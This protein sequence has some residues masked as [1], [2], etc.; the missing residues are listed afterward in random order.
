MAAAPRHD[1]NSAPESFSLETWLNPASFT[2]QSPSQQLCACKPPPALLAPQPPSVGSAGGIPTGKSGKQ[3]LGL[4][5]AW[6]AGSCR[7]LTRVPQC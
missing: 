2:Q 5:P 4:A 1:T 7:L 3:T 6:L